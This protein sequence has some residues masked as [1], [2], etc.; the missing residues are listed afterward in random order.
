MVD[1]RY[2]YALVGTRS[3]DGAWIL[4][5][6]PSLPSEVRRR[7]LAELRRQGFDADQLLWTEHPLEVTAEAE[8]RPDLGEDPVP[9]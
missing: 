1:E 9:L 4:A 3:R 7:Y 6:T 5:R 2:R 8:Q